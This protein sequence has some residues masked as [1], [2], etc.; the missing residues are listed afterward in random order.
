MFVALLKR[1]ICMVVLVVKL[2]MLAVVAF[3]INTSI[4]AATSVAFSPVNDSVGNSLQSSADKGRPIIL[5][6][7]DSISA[8]Y[9][10]EQSS[11]WVTL[12]EEKLTAKNLWYK[13]VNASVSGSTSADGLRRLPNL[14][15]QFS[16]RVVII[17]LGGNDGLRG[18]PVKLMKKNLQQMIDLSQ[19]S[20]ADVLLAGIEIP[21]NYGMRYTTLFKD[22]FQQLAATNRDIQYDPFI[23]D[24]VA[25]KPELMQD[26]GIHPT[27]AAQ[28]QLLINIWDNLYPLLTPQP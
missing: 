8:A 17:E 5:V 26:D 28:P 25:T 2:V 19:S 15:K 23:L 6:V 13:V 12:L 18:Y 4:A 16:P 14:L 3:S 22:A 21:P 1:L 7:G 27:A 10:I 9:G 11:G 20:N 24:A